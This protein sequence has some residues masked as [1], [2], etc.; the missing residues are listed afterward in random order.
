M[1][2]YYCLSK[3]ERKKYVTGSFNKNA[4]FTKNYFL[5][6][7]TSYLCQT[8]IF[9]KKKKK[10]KNVSQVLFSNQVTFMKN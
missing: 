10:R 2:N 4:T 8:I 5:K 1:L 6:N 7:F 3:K 9:C